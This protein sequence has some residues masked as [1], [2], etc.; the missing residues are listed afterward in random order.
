MN[1]HLHSIQQDTLAMYRTDLSM[2][3]DRILTVRCM[4]SQPAAATTAM[5]APWANFLTLLSI[6]TKKGHR[7]MLGALVIIA[8]IALECKRLPSM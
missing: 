3:V 8:V 4:S 7:S 6:G 2:Q 1:A 5:Y